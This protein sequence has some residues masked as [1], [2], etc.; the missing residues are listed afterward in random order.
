MRL[1]KGKTYEEIYGLER[2][3]EIKD[4]I[5]LACVGKKRILHLIS[6]AELKELCKKKT[7]KEIAGDYDIKYSSLANYAH[8][9]GIYTRKAAKTIKLLQCEY[10]E[11]WFQGR[12]DKRR[13]NQKYFCTKKHYSLWMKTNSSFSN[14]ETNPQYIDGKWKENDSWSYRKSPEYK[15]W[16]NIVF[17]RDDWTCKICGARGGKLVAHHVLPQKDYP[18]LIYDIENGATLCDDCHTHKVNG[19]EYEW[20]SY[21]QEA[22]QYSALI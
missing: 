22:Q 7:L 5:T 8:K 1:S 19:H 13:M 17:E 21:F 2:S 14:P 15:E 3:E 12:I 18:E 10:C 16:R 9:N 6:P 11:E 4:R 20:V